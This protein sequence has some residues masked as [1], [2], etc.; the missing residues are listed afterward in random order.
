[1]HESERVKALFAEAEALHAEALSRV[2]EAAKHWDRRELT[3][4]AEKAWAATLQATNALILA[5]TGVE[6][7]LNVEN[8]SEITSRL[9]RLRPQNPGFKDLE[10][11]FATQSE[12]LFHLVLCNGNLD[13]LEDT[14][15]DI[16]DT[17]DF[18]RDCERLAE[19]SR[20]DPC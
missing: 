17:A 8:D 9:L 10:G 18:I 7:K 1:M 6:T 4:A 3:R 11:R 14:I 19:V 2:D 13:P 5:H 15:A 20:G 16:R 12:F